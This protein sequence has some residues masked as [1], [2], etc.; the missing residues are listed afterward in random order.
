MAGAYHSAPAPPAIL[1][2]MSTRETL[3]MLN[4]AHLFAPLHRA[5]IHGLNRDQP[6][7]VS[8]WD[9]CTGFDSGEPHC[10]SQIDNTTMA[11]T[12]RNSLCQF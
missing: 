10:L 7:P 2:A 4:V 1:A 12:A 6:F 11:K 3:P 9:A 5:F 8:L